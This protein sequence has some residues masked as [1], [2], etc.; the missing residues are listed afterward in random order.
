MSK[1][2]LHNLNS[3]WEH[4]LSFPMIKIKYVALVEESILEAFFSVIP[5]MQ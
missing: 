2:A 5:L 3:V 4:S 1:N